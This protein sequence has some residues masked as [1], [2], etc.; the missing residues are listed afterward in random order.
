VHIMLRRAEHIL[1]QMVKEKSCHIDDPNVSGINCT[2]TRR[3]CDVDGNIQPPN[4][5]LN[6]GDHATVCI[7][8]SRY[9]VP[10]VPAPH[11]NSI[12]YA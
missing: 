4:H 12:D 10:L 5:E 1:G 8:D 3:I 6:D 9:Y 2:I 11:F 7:I